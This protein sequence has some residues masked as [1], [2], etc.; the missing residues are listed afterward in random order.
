MASETIFLEQLYE[1]K[2]EEFTLAVEA[3]LM[4]KEMLEHWEREIAQI[5][6]DMAA[7]KKRMDASV[8]KTF[9]EHPYFG[10]T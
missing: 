5:T 2:Q 1:S 7:I 3:R 8:A 4:H 9:T 6:R 10:R